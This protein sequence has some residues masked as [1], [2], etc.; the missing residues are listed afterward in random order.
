MKAWEA[1]RTAIQD[2][3]VHKLRSALTMLGVIF[4]VGSVVAML[5]IGEGAKRQALEMISQ[6]GVHNVL[7]RAKKIE[8]NALEEIRK[9]SPGVSS[10]DAQAIKE[11]VPGVA[12]VSTRV[13][14]E[15]RKTRAPGTSSDAKVQGISCGR[16]SPAVGTL[17]EGRF[18]DE[19]DERDHAQVCLVSDSVRRDLFGYDSALGK[20]VKVGRVWLE[21][22]G[23]ISEPAGEQRSGGASRTGISRQIYLPVTTALRKFPRDPL[24]SP[25]DEI[26]IRLDDDESPINSSEVIRSLVDRVHGGAS[27]FEIV[28]PEELIERQRQTQHLFSVVMGAIAGI[29]LL[30]G[31]IGITNIMLATVLERTPEIGIRRAVGARSSDIRVQFLAEAFAISALGGLTGVL[32]GTAISWTVSVYAGWPTIITP[33]SVLL[34]AS[35]ALA[36]GLVS[37]VYPAHRAATMNPIEALRYE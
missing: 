6:M 20:D 22:V 32:L 33:L 5:S 3:T 28:V 2:L 1:I 36:V 15:A 27:D 31:G 7:L 37:G 25:L 21:V 18:L 29:S 30:V 26:V 19:L 13:D 10:R 24:E 23:V 35:V 34:S 16:A 9:K 14:V 17:R 11:G 4:G 12:S 8:K